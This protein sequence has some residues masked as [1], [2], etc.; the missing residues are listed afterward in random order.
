[1]GTSRCEHGYLPGYCFCYEPR[2]IETLEDAERVY[3]SGRATPLEWERCYSIFAKAGYTEKAANCLVLG[4]EMIRKP[5]DRTNLAE[6]I[7][8]YISLQLDSDGFRE[9]R[10]PWLRN[11]ADKL[12][13]RQSEARKN[14]QN[15]FASYLDEEIHEASDMAEALILAKDGSKYA[16]VRLAKKLRKPRKYD[17]FVRWNRPLFALQIVNELL[18]AN[19]HNSYARNCR[20]AIHLDLGNITDSLADSEASI[21]QNPND[22]AAWN[23]N[24]SAHLAAGDGNLAWAPLMKCWRLEKTAPVLAMM[25]TAIGLIAL[26]RQAIPRGHNSIHDW[27]EWIQMELAIRIGVEDA[28][29]FQLVAQIASLRNLCNLALF[30]E[31]LQ[32]LAELEREGWHGATVFWDQEVRKIA[33]ASEP[34]LNLPTLQELI[35]N[36]ADFFP[37]N[38]T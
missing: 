23:I 35:N 1:M 21:G 28:K 11:L 33:R 13:R 20:A 17:K 19:P 3:N 15:R 30:L 10:G 27:R 25:Y 4:I 38:I 29:K 32:F 37:D 26:R 5:S 8:D 12:R 24:A 31:A 22:K 34:E 36:P 14:N 18:A 9:Q 16:L 2:R 7:G 6:L